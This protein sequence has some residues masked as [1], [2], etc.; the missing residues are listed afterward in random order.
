VP[1]ADAGWV[2]A[3]LKQHGIEFKVIKDDQMSAE[4]ETFRAT[5]TTFGTQSF[6]GHQSLAVEGDWA[7]ERRPGERRAVRADRAAEGAAG[8]DHAG[9]ARRRRPAGVGRIQ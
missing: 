3:K 6:E 4:V 8:D 2:G 7:R 5:K 1:V 9:T